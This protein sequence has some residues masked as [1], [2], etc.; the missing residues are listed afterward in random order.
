VTLA[1]LQKSKKTEFE[2]LQWMKYIDQSNIANA[3]EYCVPL[4]QLR[5]MKT[6]MV[7]DVSGMKEDLNIEAN[8]YTYMLSRSPLLA[9]AMEQELLMRP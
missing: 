2:I 4:D 8:E 7:P 6:D 5:T 9:V 3:C 1:T